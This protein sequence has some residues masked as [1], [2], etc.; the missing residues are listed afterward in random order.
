MQI[1]GQAA[2]DIFNDIRGMIIFYLF[3]MEEAA[4]TIGMASYLA[5]K[6]GFAAESQE[7]ASWGLNEVIGPARAFCSGIGI[8]AYPMNDAFNVFFDAS[9]RALTFYATHQPAGE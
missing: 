8:A 4:Q 3:I 6:D 1:P 2:F 9:E 7:H 5:Y